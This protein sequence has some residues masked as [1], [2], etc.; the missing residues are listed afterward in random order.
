M[1][2]AQIGMIRYKPF[3]RPGWSQN[4]L[5]PAEGPKSVP[6]GLFRFPIFR[7]TYIIRNLYYAKIALLSSGP[8]C[9]I[10]CAGR[11][12]AARP[13]SKKRTLP[14]AVHRDAGC[15]FHNIKYRTIVRQKFICS[16]RRSRHSTWAGGRGTSPIPYEPDGWLQSHI[17][18]AAPCRLPAVPV[19]ARHR[20]RRS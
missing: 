10:K 4:Q 9:K 14:C 18:H 20:W 11:L 1:K 12:H 16:G 6:K 2:N 3:G 13:A 7:I 17:R 5:R 8:G 19:S 15:V